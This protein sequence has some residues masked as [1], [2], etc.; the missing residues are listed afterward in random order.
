MSSPSSPFVEVWGF[1]SPGTNSHSWDVRHGVKVDSLVSLADALDAL[2]EKSDASSVLSSG[3]T[4]CFRND[5]SFVKNVAAFCTSECISAGCG[6]G[7]WSERGVR[8]PGT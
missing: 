1:T 2:E 5:A 7:C 8:S 3:A 4:L 6:V